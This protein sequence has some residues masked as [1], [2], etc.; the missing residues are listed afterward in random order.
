MRNDAPRALSANSAIRVAGG[1]T[2]M[3]IA[4]SS[5]APETIAANSAPE[6]RSPFIFQFPATS[7]RRGSAEFTE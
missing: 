1:H 5:R 7:G 4:V 2:M 6:A 3:W